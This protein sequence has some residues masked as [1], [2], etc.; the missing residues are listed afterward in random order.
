V[1]PLLADARVDEIARMIAG[2][3]VTQAARA[4]AEELLAG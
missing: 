2:A 1:V 3:E 4:A